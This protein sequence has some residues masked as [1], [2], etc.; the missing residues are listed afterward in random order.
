VPKLI[1]YKAFEQSALCTFTQ[2][3]INF[4][5]RQRVQPLYTLH[6]TLYTLHYLPLPF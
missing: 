6:F 4:F 2:F 3:A 1:N 5:P